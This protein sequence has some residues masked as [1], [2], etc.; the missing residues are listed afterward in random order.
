MKKKE[1]NNTAMI[2]FEL[3]INVDDDR[4]LDALANIETLSE[5]V[6]NTAFNY[7]ELNADL[8][9]IDFD[10]PLL[11]GLSLS[12]D[13]I[14]HKYNKEFRGIDRPTNVLSFANMDDD[15]FTSEDELYDE[16]ELGD[17]IIAYETTQREADEKH[18]SLHDH[19]CHLLVHGLLHLMGYDHQLDAE[20][21]V[22][23]GHEINILKEL[24]IPNPYTE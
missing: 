1:R 13:D 12:N 17:I 23:E 18:I 2:S 6:A 11:I 20:A 3:G 15:D 10:K 16:V 24:N 21:E 9:S 7:M 5:N 8:S 4:W 22:M 14:V 19:Y